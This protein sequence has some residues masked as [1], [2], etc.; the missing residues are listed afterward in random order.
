MTEYKVVEI[1]L[2]IN[3]EGPKAGELAVFVRLQGCNLSCSYCDTA[4]ANE[5]HAPCRCMTVPAI[6]REVCRF[7]VKNV[8]LTGGEPLLQP[9][10]KELLLALTRAEMEVEI[11]TNGSVSLKPFAGLSENISFTMDY[12][13]PGSGM[14]QAMDRN[15]FKV[16]TERDAVKFVVSDRQDLLRALA[17]AKE[18]LSQSGCQIFLSPVFGKIQPD[19][20]VAFMKEEQFTRARLQLQLHKLIWDPEQRGV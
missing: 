18:D 2:S 9:E 14:E 19:E 3:G 7:G 16:L 15:N 17:V 10:V 8:T 11:E 1:F 20:I 6:V 4:W 5:E 12:K 13:L